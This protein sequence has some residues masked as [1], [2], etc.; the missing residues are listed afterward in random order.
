MH[1]LGVGVVGELDKLADEAAAAAAAAKKDKKKKKDKEEKKDKS[2]KAAGGGAAAVK[3]EDSDS[4]WAGERICRVSRD[5]CR[6]DALL[7][8]DV[9][10]EAVA[11]RAAES[12]VRSALPGGTSAAC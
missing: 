5:F 2:S 3:E 6:C 11:K 8:V 12:E 4:D 1:S 10:D 7:P 9:S